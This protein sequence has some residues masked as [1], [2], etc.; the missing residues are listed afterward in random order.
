MNHTQY[1]SAWGFF[2]REYWSLGVGLIGALL[3]VP[4]LALRLKRSDQPARPRLLFALSLAV[5]SLVAVIVVQVSVLVLM[6]LVV[7]GS[8]FRTALLAAGG[9]GIFA[10][11]FA[12]LI[13]FKGFRPTRALPFAPRG[14]LTLATGSS[15]FAIMLF[16]LSGVGLAACGPDGGSDAANLN[17]IGNSLE[18]YRDQ[19]GEF[20]TDLRQLVDAGL[21]DPGALLPV[22]SDWGKVPSGTDFPFTGPCGWHYAT[23]KAGAPDE[24]LRAWRMPC[25]PGDEFLYVLDSTGRV[26]TL[27]IEE[28][29]ARLRESRPFFDGPVQGP[30]LSSAVAPPP[31][32]AVAARPTSDVA[33]LPAN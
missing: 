31:T 1:L 24:T 2:P 22:R 5:S 32:P 11:F 7:R 21:L 25:G 29:A 17:G 20:P 23:L 15:A 26:P 28:L 30:S 12:P 19:I 4:L 27:T 16:V 8:G 9:A 13:T 3:L 6:G 10:A 33:A 18:L 14:V